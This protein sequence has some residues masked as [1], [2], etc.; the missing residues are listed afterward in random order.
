VR[1]SNT[2]AVGLYK[3]VG[4]EISRAAHG[5]YANGEDAY[6]MSKKLSS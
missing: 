6:I 2:P 1:V 4:F 3:K 5:Y